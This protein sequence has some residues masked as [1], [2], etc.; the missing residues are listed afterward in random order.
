MQPTLGRIVHYTLSTG[1]AQLI[2]QPGLANATPR[3]PVREGQVYPAM[4]VA[5]F[6]PSVTT[7]NLKVFLDGGGGAEYWA[8][9]RTEGEG[10]CHWAWPPRV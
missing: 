10:P 2:N 5:V 4:V 3:N 9:S 6:D 8:T 7:A 1:D